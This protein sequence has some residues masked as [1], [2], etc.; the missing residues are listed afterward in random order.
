MQQIRFKVGDT[1]YYEAPSGRVW[2][3]IVSYTYE[4]EIHI[5]WYDDQSETSHEYHYDALREVVV[6]CEYK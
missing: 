6:Q 1:V 4:M 3:G 5:K 2:M